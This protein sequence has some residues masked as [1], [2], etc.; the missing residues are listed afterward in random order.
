MNYLI[1]DDHP[2]IRHSYSQIIK[3]ICGTVCTI[4]H[5]DSAEKAWSNWLVRQHQAVV[6]DINLPDVSGIDLAARILRRKPSTRLMFFSMHDEQGLVRK[7]LDIGAMAYVS[8]SAEPDEF[9][10]AIH[11]ISE[12]KL[13]VEQRLAM[14]LV[15]P[16]QAGKSH[17][18]DVLS[19]R[20]R[21]IFLMSAK[22]YS[23]R[24]VGELLNVS[25]K[26]VANNLSIIK[27]KLNVETTAAMAHL[28]MKHQLI[29]LYQPNGQPEQP[30][31]FAS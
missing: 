16:A 3:Q 18:L 17:L 10:K 8:K 11:A 5:A 25:A 6:L 22:G 21:E 1:V 26:T 23:S 2:I 30:S 19:Q 7:A 4:E 27:Q 13:Y 20:E 29:E 15:C 12:G 28:A 24:Q 31:K 14:N 9:A